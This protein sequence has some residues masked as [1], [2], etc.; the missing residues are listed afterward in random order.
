MLELRSC[1]GSCLDLFWG[2]GGLLHVPP[3]ARLS[4]TLHI[5]SDEKKGN[6]EIKGGHRGC[7]FLASCVS[8]YYNWSYALIYIYTIE[9]N[10]YL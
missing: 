3:F 1:E 6:G 9:M 4:T 2:A 7:C 8:I 10:D 5:H